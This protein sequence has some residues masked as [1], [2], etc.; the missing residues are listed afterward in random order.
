MNNEN[1]DSLTS[2]YRHNFV[3]DSLNNIKNAELIYGIYLGMDSH[4]FS[5]VKMDEG[6]IFCGQRFQIDDA[7]FYQDSLMSISI[8]TQV[9]SPNTPSFTL[10]KIYK[11]FISKYG[12]QSAMEFTWNSKKDG[13]EDY[14]SVKLDSFYNESGCKPDYPRINRNTSLDNFFRAFGA[15]EEY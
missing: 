12:K 9:H 14:V 11:H 5:S 10:L 7:K 1:I 2:V 8:K 3:N 6:F 4:S 15:I 13:H